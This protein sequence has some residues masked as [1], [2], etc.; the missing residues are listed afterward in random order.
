[1]NNQNIISNKFD[2]FR[3]TSFSYIMTII[4]DDHKWHLYQG[5]LKGKYHCTID[6]LFDWFGISLMTT[7]NFCFYLQN[8]LIQTSQTGGQLYS[9]TSPY[10]IPCLYYE[11]GVALAL[12]RVV[13]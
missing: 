8:R 7:D 1:M 12:A 9:D 4:S 10:S 6:L 11:S 5:I 3:T 2:L 13:N